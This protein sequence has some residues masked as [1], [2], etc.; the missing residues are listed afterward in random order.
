MK[1][2]RNNLFTERLNLL[3]EQYGTKQQELAESIGT[4][5]QT[6]SLYTIGGIEP[7]RNAIVGIAKYFNTSCDYLLGVSDEP[8]IDANRQMMSEYLGLSGESIDVIRM[9][10]ENEDDK[11]TLN[12]Y[13]TASTNEKEAGRSKSR[14]EINCFVDLI[15]CLSSYGNSFVAAIP[16]LLNL[17]HKENEMGKSVIEDDL[18][19]LLSESNLLSESPE[20]IN[21]FTHYLKNEGTK[22]ALI[23]KEYYCNKK[24]NALLEHC[25]EEIKEVYTASFAKALKEMESA[26]EE[27]EDKNG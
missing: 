11:T 8:K 6:I 10:T 5:R 12:L 18:K 16:N 27:S 4:T 14:K 22:D 7:K 21:L 20:L 26:N 9:I 13:L 2:Q 23:A 25:Y 19:K 15:S 3:I 24:A 1:E 17:S